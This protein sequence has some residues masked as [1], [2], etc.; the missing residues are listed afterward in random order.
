MSLDVRSHSVTLMSSSMVKMKGGSASMK[1]PCK[2]LLSS[3][4]HNIFFGGNCLFLREYMGIVMLLLFPSFI[5]SLG[6]ITDCFIYL[7]R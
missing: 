7:V 1:Q 2:S 5:I 3:F 4:I 6:E